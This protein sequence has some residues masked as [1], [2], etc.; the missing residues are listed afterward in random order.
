MELC[1]MHGRQVLQGSLP[2]GVDLQCA[3]CYAPAK[4]VVVEVSEVP[5]EWLSKCST[6]EAWFWCGECDVGG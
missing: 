5:R 6:S 2:E 4:Q 3:D 1:D